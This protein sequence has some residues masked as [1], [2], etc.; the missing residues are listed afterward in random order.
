[1]SDCKYLDHKEAKLNA[2][3]NLRKEGFIPKNSD[4]LIEDSKLDSFNIYHEQ[5]LAKVNK[6]YGLSLPSLYTIQVTTTGEDINYKGKKKITHR[7]VPIEAS[8]NAIDSKRRE[9]GIYDSKLSIGSHNSQI[10]E[11]QAR[12]EQSLADEG[13]FVFEGEVYPSRQDMQA[14][15]R[16]A[17]QM[18]FYMPIGAK[19]YNPTNY[20]DVISYKVDLLSKVEKRLADVR[21]SRQ[22][23]KSPT[24]K[25]SIVELNKLKEKLE[26][27]ISG[28]KTDP[29][30]YER[31]LSIFNDDIALISK[32][33]NSTA[34]SLEDIHLAEEMIT[35][36][37]LI[38]NYSSTNQGND[39]VDT[40]DSSLIE[41]DVKQ[42]LNDLSYKIHDLQTDLEKAKKSYLIEAI[43]QSEK[44]KSLF[45]AQQSDE[46][47]RDFLKAKDDIS[48]FSM[49]FGT[50]D[51]SFSG[52]ETS[53]AYMIKD[54]LDQVRDR[55]KSEAI[56]HIQA[57]NNLQD[58]VKSILLS[59]G[60]GITSKAL[61]KFNFTSEVN[62]TLFYQ[63]TSNGN[64][65]GRLIHRFS[66]RWF[67]E[68][69]SFLRNTSNNLK[70]AYH[71]E[72]PVAINQILSDKY[73]WLAERTDFIQLHKIP[74]IVNNPDFAPF[75]QH[76][77]KAE[78]ENYKKQLI[79]TIGEDEYNRV[80]QEQI[81]AIEDYMH[82]LQDELQTRLDTY[83]VSRPSELPEN[84]IHN[85]NILSKRHS[86]FDFI[87]SH[88]SGQ[89]GRVD[90]VIGNQG[91]QYQS[92]LRYNTYIPKANLTRVNMQDGT[93]Y[94]QDSNYYDK[95][96]DAIAK[97]PDLLAFWKVL[98]DSAQY[99]NSAIND[100]NTSLGHNSLLRMSKSMTDL[101]LSKDTGVMGLSSFLL[102]ET[103]QALKDMISVKEQN[104]SVKDTLE[105]SKNGIET[106]NAE[107]NQRFSVLLMELSRAAD[108]VLDGKSKIVLLNTSQEFQ[109]IFTRVTGLSPSSIINAHGSEITPNI[110]REYLTNQVMEEQTFNLP[111]M[112]KA[113]LDVASEYKA[114]K[115]AL[116]KVNIFKDLYDNIQL[117]KK[118][119]SKLG[120]TT[121]MKTESLA[122][123]LARKKREAGL[124][125]KRF[126]GQLRLNTWIERNVKGIQESEYWIKSSKKNY[127][128]EEKKYKAEAEKYIDFLNTKIETVDEEQQKVLQGEINEIQSQLENLGQSVALASIYNTIINKL[129]VLVGLGYNIPTQFV[130]RFQ[131]W[132]SGM[133]ND[134]GRYWTAGNFYVANAFINRKGLRR[135]PGNKAYRNE[136]RKAKLLIERM[137]VI[138]D[139]TNEL[140]KARRQSGITGLTKVFNPFYLVEYTEWHNQVPQI[141]AMLQDYY[142]ENPNKLDSQGN[143]IKVQV[144]DGNSFPAFDIKNGELVLTDDLATE[145]NKATWE[146][147]SDQTAADIKAKV[148]STIAF[149]NGDYSK[150][151]SLMAKN[152]I[153]GKTLMLF[154]TWMPKQYAL[155]FSR[156]QTNL[157]L[158]LKDFDGAYTGSLKSDKTSMAATAGL[159]GISA[160]GVL[161]G[162]GLFYGSLVGGSLLGYGIY[163]QVKAKLDGENLHTMKQLSAMGQ[164]IVKKAIGIPVNTISGKN[165]IKA[166]EFNSLNLSPQEKENLQFIVNELTGLLFLLLIKVLVKTSMQDDKDKEP[167]YLVINGVK[168][169]NPNYY[170]QIQSEEEKEWYNLLENM[171]S[172]LI[173]DSTLF[174][175]PK[176]LF[177]TAGTI[178]AL[179]RWF[180]QG[181]KVNDGIVRGLIKDTDVMTSGVDAGKSKLGTALRSTF[182]PGIFNDVVEGNADDFGFGKM[183]KQEYNKTE[184]LDYMMY[185][186]YKKDR[187]KVKSKRAEDKARIEDYYT[188][189]EN[190][191]QIKDPYLLDEA[192][193]RIAKYTKR[194]LDK[195][196][197]LDI[198]A[199]YDSEQNKIE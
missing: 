107:V 51:E 28:L 175:D 47:A 89:Q 99:I 48:V 35:Y 79:N 36:F 3:Q 114:Q 101:L 128:E 190:L 136:I 72:D 145:E 61:S 68:L 78:A 132:W 55:N 125:D 110:L 63:K 67:T 66:H 152:S 104:K 108:K 50:V 97:E 62:Y 181:D 156:N 146:N 171:V 76:F 188:A 124:E 115:Q 106:I 19:V 24:L 176:Q 16:E 32:I 130:N 164:A 82:Y 93:I 134:T 80:V 199:N 91:N 73:H 96:F 2:L 135:L 56:S 38:S 198:R 23:D 196:Y 121:E 30:I 139:N 149:L 9:I 173:Q 192:K 1:M 123:R 150:T 33:L 140:D 111:L 185:S 65:T 167:K 26:R 160:I 174:T 42:V 161:T 45:P 6:S 41:P 137:S 184:I 59:K 54:T 49:L 77:E 191:D 162:V 34:P 87:D 10:K 39:F 113:Y 86:P 158:G 74:E 116:P 141:L 98:N 15:Q 40:S 153:L 112:M 143:P 11:A 122:L 84:V 29:D 52:Q 126:R 58:R 133:V 151:G 83:K 105:V 20:S 154:K 37:R 180:K 4:R 165:L 138:Q 95:S 88:N 169:V 25:N 60:Y 147:F 186:D 163:K 127:T 64:K 177:Q 100:S 182:L 131:G 27:D 69:S 197:P 90:Y 81:E 129:G 144:F 85:Y 159:V 109:N 22:Y 44:I 142:I 166:H 13:E 118:E 92:H 7:I 17:E 172:K 5:E 157:A 8:F 46:I 71:N 18:N 179:D 75:E 57:I 155:R 31:T 70:E 195:Y 14:A 117:E 94:E 102:K 21:A 170:K 103:G 194:D 178:N 187:L 193:K 183:M 148:S 168:T 189:Q 43:E 53:L 120:F 12:E 119:K